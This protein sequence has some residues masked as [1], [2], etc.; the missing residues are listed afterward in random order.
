M[1]L[2]S[3]LPNYSRWPLRNKVPLQDLKTCLVC[4]LFQGQLFFDFGSPAVAAGLFSPVPSNDSNFVPR[5]SLFSALLGE[6]RDPGNEFP[7]S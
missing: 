7:V 5:A 2:V 1:L 4:R 6:K 3:D